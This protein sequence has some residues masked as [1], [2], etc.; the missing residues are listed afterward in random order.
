MS[1][2]NYHFKRDYLLD[3]KRRDFSPSYYGFEPDKI[4]IDELDLKILVELSK[5]CSQNNMKIGEKLGVTYQTIKQRIMKLEDS[6]IIQSHRILFD[7]SKIGREYHKIMMKLNNPS[8]KEEKELYEF[9][10]SR[11]FVVYLVEVLGDIQM[12]IETEVESQDEIIGL[13]R[14]IKNE[15][16]N[17]IVDYDILQ[18]IKEHKLNYL[19]MGN[20]LLE[21]EK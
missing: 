16:P 6:K 17:L 8:K 1:V 20:E 15:F 7:I 10:S 9:C 5:N 14:D 21:I 19:P 3:K 13:L 18:V 11:N 2:V 4:K 12:E